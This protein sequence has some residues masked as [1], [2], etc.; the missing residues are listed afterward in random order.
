MFLCKADPVGNEYIHDVF[1]KYCIS[2][3]S[4]LQVHQATRSSLLTD[5]TVYL[6]SLPNLNTESEIYPTETS[7]FPL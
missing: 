2:G 3:I 6:Q 4:P 5:G 1:R 7:V